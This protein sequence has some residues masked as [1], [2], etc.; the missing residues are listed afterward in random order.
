MA[1]IPS[2]VLILIEITERRL[3]LYEKLKHCLFDGSIFLSYDR[4][5]FREE[6]FE[7]NLSGNHWLLNF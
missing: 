4:L 6:Y 5:I 1:T 2:L 3:V 7:L